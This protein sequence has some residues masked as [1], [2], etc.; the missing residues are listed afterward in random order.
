MM[1][2]LAKI[3]VVLATIFAG[4]GSVVVRGGDHLLTILKSAGLDDYLSGRLAGKVDR[5]VFDAI[6]RSAPLDALAA[7]LLYRG[8]HDAGSQVWAGCGDWLF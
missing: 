3:L 4:F 6:P 7:G 5:A 2:D 1:A 8:L